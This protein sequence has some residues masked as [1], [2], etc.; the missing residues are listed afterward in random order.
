MASSCSSPLCHSCSVSLRCSS[1]SSSAER[2][3][4][5]A[6]RSS[7]RPDTQTGSEPAPK[8]TVL[9]PHL[10]VALRVPAVMKRPLQVGLQPLQAAPQLLLHP[11]RPPPRPLAGL[12]LQLSPEE[13][14]LQGQDLP[15]SLVVSRL[16]AEPETDDSGEAR[17]SHD[18]RDGV[19][20]T[21][22]AGCGRRRRLENTASYSAPQSP[23]AAPQPTHT[24][25]HTRVMQQSAQTIGA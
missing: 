7:W 11:G 15:L 3:F 22:A 13:R 6:C 12:Q 2:S 25:T 5:R 1:L 24:H 17:E 14:R 10:V 9:V 20:D 23:E 18:L 21:P 8:R 16:Q 4:C 19:K